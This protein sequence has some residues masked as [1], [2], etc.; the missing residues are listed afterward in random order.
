MEKLRFYDLMRL[1]R[2][3]AFV[4][5]ML[6]DTTFLKKGDFFYYEIWKSILN[7]EKQAVRALK[8]PALQ[9]CED[10]LGNCNYMGIYNGYIYWGTDY[11][12]VPLTVKVEADAFVNCV[13]TSTAE[14]P[15]SVKELVQDYL[16]YLYDNLC[17]ISKKVQKSKFQLGYACNNEDLRIRTAS[18]L[19]Y[20]MIEK[21]KILKNQTIN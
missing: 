12:C 19:S 5:R 4:R 11:C 20:Y 9:I 1:Q 2:Q 18:A 7:T 10:K 15:Y 17:K 3:R 6:N 8:L 21:T 14:Y 16:S 13:I